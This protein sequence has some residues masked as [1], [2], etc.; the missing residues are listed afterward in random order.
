MKGRRRPLRDI[1]QSRGTA[2]SPRRE[3]RANPALS[4]PGSCGPVSMEKTTARGPAPARH[5]PRDYSRTPMNVYWEV[6]RACAL[7]CRHCRAEAA[8]VADPMQLTFDEGVALLGQIRE[9]GDPLPQLILTGGDPLA[10][11]DLYELLDEACGLGNPGCSPQ[12]ARARSRRARPVPNTPG[13]NLLFFA[14]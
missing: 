7:A 14:G 4:V 10:R 1:A 11:G 8:P 13:A 12:A 9:F 2:Q 5:A 6:T 3:T